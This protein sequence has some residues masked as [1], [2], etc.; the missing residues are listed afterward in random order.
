M[1]LPELVEAEAGEGHDHDVFARGADGRFCVP[2]ARRVLCLRFPD[3]EDV[4]PNL[5]QDFRVAAAGRP[6]V[7]EHLGRH[8]EAPGTKVDS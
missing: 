5:G 8:R 6:L 7:Q 1:S 2:R 4:L 3:V